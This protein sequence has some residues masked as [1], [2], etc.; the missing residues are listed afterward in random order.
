MATPRP[1]VHSHKYLH[2]A[3]AGS[4]F[5]FIAFFPLTYLLVFFFHSSSTS[6]LFVLPFLSPNHG[7]F[8]LFVGCP[9]RVGMSSEFLIPHFIIPPFPPPSHCKLSHRLSSVC[10]RRAVSFTFVFVLLPVARGLLCSH[11]DA[12]FGLA[13]VRFCV[14]P[15]GPWVLIAVIKACVGVSSL[16]DW[17]PSSALR[18]C[19][20]FSRLVDIVHESFISCHCRIWILVP[21]FSF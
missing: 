8:L 10:S 16:T 15:K 6:I 5:S 2:A 19:M 1:S 4:A 20:L 11:V 21:V 13:I 7:S 17:G 18:A 14:L 3:R 9:S 12:R